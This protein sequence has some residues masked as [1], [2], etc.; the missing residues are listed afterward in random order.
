M[1]KEDANGKLH[2]D[3]TGKFVSKGS[4]EEKKSYD[5]RDDFSTLKKR[6]QGATEGKDVKS[7][8]APEDKTT[9]KEQKKKVG[10]YVE[11]FREGE[12]VESE[13]VLSGVGEKEREAIEKLTGEKLTATQHVLCL[14]ELRHIEKRHGRHG[15]H[16]HSMADIEKYEQI[17]EVLK[18]PDSVDFCLDKKGERQYSYNYRDKNNRPAKLLT[19]TKVY[20]GYEQMVVEAVCDSKYG[21]LHVITSYT[22]K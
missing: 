2:G 21:K 7:Q 16:D 6:V 13:I 19:F 9:I 8:A 17:I 12:E 10:D 14:S 18:N 4:G 11:R 22:K 15:E 1:P 3:H 20:D 5:S